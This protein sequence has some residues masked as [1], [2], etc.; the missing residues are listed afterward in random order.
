MLRNSF[1]KIS[2]VG[3]IAAFASLFS[4]QAFAQD[5]ATLKKQMEQRLPKVDSLKA[6]GTIGEGNTGYLVCLKGE[7]G[8]DV[9]A[10]ENAD[11]A[12]V[13]GMIAK[14]ESTTADLVG[15]RR[16]VQIAQNAKAGEMIQ[17][18]DGKWNKK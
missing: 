10:A 12:A 8:K 18:A 13:Y 2:L 6:Q 4:V 7:Q 15:K 1:V 16:A 3:V 17:S 9:V 14:K 11:R 5:A